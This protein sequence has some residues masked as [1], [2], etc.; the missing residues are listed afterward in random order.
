V[1][2]SSNLFYFRNPFTNWNLSSWRILPQ[3]LA[4]IRILVLDETIG[5]PSITLNKNNKKQWS[6]L[7]TTLGQM[8]RL[9]ALYFNVDTLYPNLWSAELEKQLL[10]PL[11]GFRHLLEM[12]VLVRWAKPVDAD[13]APDWFEK[14]MQR[15]LIRWDSDDA[16]DDEFKNS[17]E[18][19][20]RRW[21]IGK[22]GAIEKGEF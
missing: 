8:S 7:W 14:E 20:M 19:D 16:T 11:A 9:K 22:V 15:P 4:Q 10:G 2:Y 5:N 12:H 21:I 1:L 18:G 3:R 6:H 17:L 13:S